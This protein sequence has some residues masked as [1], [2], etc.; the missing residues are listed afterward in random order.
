MKQ[1]VQVGLIA[2]ALLTGAMTTWAQ[3]VDF[4]GTWTL[5]PSS[6]TAG[7]DEGSLLGSG[8]ATVTQTAET[9]TVQRVMDGETVTLTYRLD[10]GDS[11]N[12]LPTGDGRQI[13]AFSTVKWDGS[14][15]TIVSKREAEGK[16]LEATETWTVNGNTLTAVTTGGPTARKTRLYKR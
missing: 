13:D 3:K 5:D 2:T 11:R 1:L 7:D 8:R 16:L 4:S 15:L 14:T 10:G 12:I 9:L 6:A